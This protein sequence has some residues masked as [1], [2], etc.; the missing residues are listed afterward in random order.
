MIQPVYIP[1]PDENTWKQAEVG[2]REIW[3]FPNCV[4][5]IDGKHVAIKCPPNS[6]SEYFC[7]K[8]FFS[9]V[10]LAIVDPCYKFL[11]VDIGNYGR[12]SD[13]GIFQQSTFYREYI[14]QKDILPPKPLPGT[15]EPVPHV[16][17]GDEG[18]ALQPFLMRPFSKSIV[19]HD[20]RKKQYNYRLCRA[21]RVVENAF[22]ILSQKWRIFLRPIECNVEV[23]IDV[24]KAACCLHNYLRSKQGVFVVNEVETPPQASRSAFRD[25]VPTNRRSPNVAFE[26]REKFVTYF[27]Q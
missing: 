27:N 1:T 11:V 19:L 9:I 26:I 25:F 10:L 14:D 22:G 17:I 15:D 7:Y 20:G 12:H 13:S 6:G 4:G 8:N 18:F 24:V 5:S 16:L 3:N 23:A 2:Y 21:R